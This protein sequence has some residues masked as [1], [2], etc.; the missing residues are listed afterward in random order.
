M[1]DMGE[2]EMPI[3]DNTTP[4]MN[5]WGKY[6]AIEMGGMFS[7]VKV[8]EGIAANDY[9]DPGWYDSPPRPPWP[10]RQRCARADAGCRCGHPLH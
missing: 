9:S 2:M 8:R 5:G 7:V 3:P 6:G 10:S 4:M 1:A